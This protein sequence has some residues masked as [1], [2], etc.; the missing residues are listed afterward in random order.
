MKFVDPDRHEL[1]MAYH[2]EGMDIG[3]VPGKFK[4]VEP[5]GYD[6][7]KFKT[8]YSRWDSAFAQKG[9]VSIYLGNHDQPRMVTRWGNDQPAFRDLS[10]KMLTTFL[11]TMRG[12]PYCYYGDELGMANIK[13]NR[14][15]DYRDIETINKYQEI[16][17][18]H[19]DLKEFIES[20][21]ISARDNGRTPF[22]W[23]SSSNAGFSTGKPWLPV[24]PDYKTVNEAAQEN[25]TASCLNYFRKMI[26]LRKNNLVLVYGRYTLL[27]KDNPNVYAYAR[28][29]N[30]KKLLVLLNF[31]SSPAVAHTGM[32]IG[33]ATMLLDNYPRPSVSDTLRPYE[34]TVYELMVDR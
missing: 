29:L 17:N 8:V 1:N 31:K 22:Q 9:W 21:K 18:G 34:A 16:K 25:D 4:V 33:R 28:E 7:L 23:D 24:N 13:F 32:D 3:Y 5:A 27:D 6:L 10:S 15:E 12:T 11:L 2:F 20:Q 30:G 26:R 14:I 19:G